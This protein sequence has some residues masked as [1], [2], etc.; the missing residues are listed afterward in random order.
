MLKI[1]FWYLITS[2]IVT[3][4]C[5]DSKCSYCSTIFS[6]Y[7]V[8]YFS[9][10]LE[11]SAFYLPAMYYRVCMYNKILFKWLIGIN[12]MCHFGHTLRWCR[13]MIFG[14]QGSPRDL[15]QWS[16]RRT[17]TELVIIR[18]A[19]KL[20]IWPDVGKLPLLEKNKY[21]FRSIYVCL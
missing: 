3:Y 4:I 20:L 10:A 7:Q 9:E 16:A 13:K 1:K 19:T 12:Q 6:I 14:N 8:L 17:H 11:A 21:G 5:W 15:K 18:T 2:I